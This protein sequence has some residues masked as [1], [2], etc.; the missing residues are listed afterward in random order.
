[1]RVPARGSPALGAVTHSAPGGSS[2]HPPGPSGAGASATAPR[3]GGLS[4]PRARGAGQALH[5]GRRRGEPAEAGSD[6]LLR[7][8]PSV[9]PAALLGLT[10]WRTQL[11]GVAEPGTRRR[12]GRAGPR[13]AF[14][15]EALEAE[16]R[17]VQGPEEGG[18]SAD[19]EKGKEKGK[20]RMHWGPRRGSDTL[21]MKSS[22]TEQWRL[23]TLEPDGVRAA[24]SGV[25]VPGW[26]LSRWEPPQPPPPP[27]PVSWQHC[28]WLLKVAGCLSAREERR[29]NGNECW[30][31]GGGVYLSAVKIKGTPRR[32]RGG[33]RGASE[34]SLAPSQS[35]QIRL[36][37][38]GTGRHS[39]LV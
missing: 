14:P 22:L 2:L 39:V 37:P 19:Q 6:P 10:D 15:R 16:S 13:R 11:A 1:M 30:G 31:P 12:R 26:P 27:R 7:T 5:S 25:R 36:V 38:A 24:P 32:S 34:P 9:C 20:Q 18:V 35:F 28:P 29:P 33:P 21:D 3:L 8:L 23:L 17:R 4:R